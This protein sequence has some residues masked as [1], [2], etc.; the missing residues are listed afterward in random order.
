MV[1]NLQLIFLDYLV[2][3]PLA[4]KMPTIATD[5]PSEKL[6]LYHSNYGG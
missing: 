2:H 5:R 3:F 6:H 4:R 1:L